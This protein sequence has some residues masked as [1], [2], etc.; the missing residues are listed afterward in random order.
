MVVPSPQ[1]YVELQLAETG[2]DLVPAIEAAQFARVIDRSVPADPAEEATIESFAELFAAAAEGW[3]EFVA[4]ER[5]G[6][7]AR[8]GDQLER[9]EAL[10]W[11]VHWGRVELALPR[12][13]GTSLQLPLAVLSIGRSGAPTREVSI[14]GAVAL[15]SGPGTIH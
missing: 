1:Q 5:G 14:P 6:L 3:E 15:D 13:D 9:L 7:L 12:P 2:M 4:A 11:F 8:L 10:D